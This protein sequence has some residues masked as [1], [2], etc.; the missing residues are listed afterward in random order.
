MLWPF[1]GT[2]NTKKTV[3]AALQAARDR[4]L[5]HVVVASN[6]GDTVYMLL[7]LD[8]TGLSLVCVTHQVGF[9][10]PGQHEM[11]ETTR[12]A[13]S[14]RGVALLTTTHLFGG[15]DRTI[16]KKH[17]GLY[18]PDIIAN[19]LR[20]FGQGVKVAV[21]I[22]IM[23]LDAGLVPHGKDIVAV[24]GSSRG[25]DAACVVRPAHSSAAFDTRV[26]DVI[27]RPEPPRD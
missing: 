1:P 4:D 12:K 27:C 25:A 18:P 9:M 17:G 8:A 14:D 5:T 13:L 10:E 23:A 6:T 11:P 26:I 20:M 7:E 19:T 22:S 15:V 24:G 3:S 21:E 16:T 2:A